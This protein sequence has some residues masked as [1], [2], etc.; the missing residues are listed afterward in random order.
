MN[1][2]ILIEFES[3]EIITSLGG[4]G[5]SRREEKRRAEC[6]TV[7]E[8]IEADSGISVIKLENAH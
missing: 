3:R 6:H 4:R 2:D 1:S 7:G 5:M 8:L